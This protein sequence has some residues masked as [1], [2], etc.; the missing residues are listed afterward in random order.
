MIDFDK[1]AY[2]LVSN[3]TKK[4]FASAFTSQGITTVI[5]V[6]GYKVIERSQNEFFGLDYLIED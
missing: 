5:T 6:N 3:T 1:P 4:R 2:Y